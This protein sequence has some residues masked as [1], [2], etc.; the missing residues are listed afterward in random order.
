MRTALLL[1]ALLLAAGCAQPSS[2]THS[3]STT[4]AGLPEGIQSYRDGTLVDAPVLALG[5]AG[6]V[7]I[8]H[9]G[10]E[11]NLG[12][13]SSGAL[14]VSSGSAVVAS[15]DAGA[16][17]KVVY[18]DPLGNSDPMLWVDTLTDRVYDVPMTVTLACS[19]I[20]TSDDDGATW[21]ANPMPECGRGAYDHQK[22]ATGVPGP[23]ANPLAGA[24]WPTVAYMCY[25]GIA[26]TNCGVSY[27]GGATW[28]WDRNTVVNV[29]PAQEGGGPSTGCGSGQNGHPTSAPDGT[30]VF[31][32]TGP[33]CP[34]PYLV[35]TRDSGLTWSFTP[36]PASPNPTS[37]D[38]EVAFTPDGTMYFLFQDAA[39]H[40][41]LARSHDLGA[42]WDGVFQVNPPGVDATSFS[43]LATGSDG[44]L[45]IAFL[46]TSA[47][48]SPTN[49]PANA[50]WGLYIVTTEDADAVSPTFT[51]YR[52]T[53]ADDPVQVGGI[54][55]GG[56]GDPSRNLLDFI[57]GSV[58]PDGTFYVAFA[59]GCTDKCAH[60]ADAKPE[61]SRASLTSVG[62][63]RGWSLYAPGEGRPALLH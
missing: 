61:D 5:K 10:A 45:A 52:A 18:D 20:Y 46:G 4:T 51:S 29:V 6:F 33:S 22:F 53:P 26:T 62:F 42:T 57:D 31:G 32:R 55:Q 15:H 41:V 43:A 63:L 58:A 8:G 39:F 30:V 36:G 7:P 48:G 12:I 14:F 60:N 2:T 23:G 27:D 44:R 16:T 50:T 13:T 3:A 21:V 25:N 54:W 11:P 34:Q 59:D 1:I 49:V 38:P 9:D 24:Q 37:L 47:S 19:R 40:Q 17:W 35:S 28:V 56:G